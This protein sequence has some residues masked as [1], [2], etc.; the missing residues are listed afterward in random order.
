MCIRF[1]IL[2]SCFFLILEHP[3]FSCQMLNRYTLLSR[4]YIDTLTIQVLYR[5]L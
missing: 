5:S 2:Y 3:A 4:L 1:Y